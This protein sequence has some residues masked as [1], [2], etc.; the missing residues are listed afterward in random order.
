MGQVINREQFENWRR[1]SETEAVFDFI[2]ASMAECV[3]AWTK[4]DFNF[5]DDAQRTTVANIAA[6]EN[7][8]AFQKLL[9][10]D[11]E[12]YSTAMKEI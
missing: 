1:Q 3:L 4:G 12:E 8:K 7:I 11:Y 5:P 10:L 9:D 2:R 6:V